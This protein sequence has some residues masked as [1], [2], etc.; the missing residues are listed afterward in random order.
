[1]KS[2]LS[3]LRIPVKTVLALLAIVTPVL[4]QQDELPLVILLGDSIRVGYQDG[5]AK[6]LDGK[7]VVWGPRENCKSSAYMRENLAKWIGEQRRPA[8]IHVNAGL[9]DLVLKEPGQNVTHLADYTEN[10]RAIIEELKTVDGAKII[11]ATTTPVVDE[12]NSAARAAGTQDGKRV[13]WRENEQ[14]IR[15]NQAAAEAIKDSGIAVDD[16]YTLV[17]EM[18][19]QDLFTEDGVHFS[20][21][22]REFLGDAV[23]KS[24]AE[25]LP[26]K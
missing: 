1:M 18:N 13:A 17:H 7:A 23:A 10:V 3:A 9:H 5:V 4:A 2:I 24:I 15:F 11:W 25:N 16:L 26:G 14:V 8:V 22:G 21:Y 19:D 6:A 20:I 12:L